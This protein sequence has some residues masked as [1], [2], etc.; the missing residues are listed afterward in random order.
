MLDWT[1]VAGTFDGSSLK[2]FINGREVT[3]LE[4]AGKLTAAK[5]VD[6]LVGRNHE[7]SPLANLIRLDYPVEF[8]FDGLFD[9]VRI[10]KRAL[11][12]G[13][14]EAAYRANI[15]AEAQALTYRKLP[16][17]PEGLRRFG[18][19][20]TRLYYDDT[21][22][23]RWRV[24][25]DPD[26]LVRFDEAPYKFVFWRGTSY[27]PCWVTENGI[28]YTNEFNETWG[29]GAEGCAEPMSDKQTKHSHVRI[30]ES[31]EARV[32]VHW[33]YGLV[34][35][36]YVFARV[37]ELTGWG[38]WSDEYYTIYPDGVG[39]RKIHLWSSQPM[40][41]HEFQE[42]IIINPPG[43]RPEDNIETDALTMVNLKGEAY[44][45]SWGEQ[46]PDRV[47]RP[48]NPIIEYINLKADYKPFLIVSEK[49]YQYYQEAID[50]YIE[51]MSGADRE[52]MLE[53]WHSLPSDELRDVYDDSL[54]QVALGLGYTDGLK[55]SDGPTFRIFAHEV[56]RGNSIF[57]WW[58]HWP[59]AQIP[60]DGR[61]ATQPD[62]VSHSSLTT[63]LEWED[64]E[65][66]ANARVRIMMHGLT[67]KPARDLALL[68]KSWL[69]PAK[70]RLSDGSAFTHE[71][72]EPAER[73]YQLST[74]ESGTPASLSF[75]LV[76][77]KESP[78][79]NPAFMVKGWGRAEMSL[80]I[81]G[82]AV[83]RGKAF[84]YGHRRTEDGFD[85]V[86]WI[87]LESTK[88]VDMTFTPTQ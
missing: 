59:V 73:A 13:E 71:G 37:D 60:S 24:G 66:T 12:A 70:V 16:S 27:I 68:A 64:Y 47:S 57:P 10:Y 54:Q 34:D 46:T 2:V 8:S 48:E 65:V 42:S 43:T 56:K 45:Y 44:T 74:K 63:G 50:E 86:V 62:R 14:I 67:N 20:T 58:N 5:G 69:R 32:V 78:I 76:A 35:N 53:E 29:H 83:D 72:Y 19:Y 39:I 18:A 3:S 38:D 52:A 75:Q 31:N 1:H 25:P 7:P 81:N 11:S 87:K 30:I 28:W 40:D 61:W 51:H 41:P 49:P 26:V 88:P 22:E 33:R 6:L 79:I 85:L 36:R 23:W 82:Q 55:E 80:K 15:P 84:R 9:E 17:G 4:A 77:S 21:W